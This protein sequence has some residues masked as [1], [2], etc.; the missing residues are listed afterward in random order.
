MDVAGYF[1]TIEPG[2]LISI[3]GTDSVRLSKNWLLWNEE[4]VRSFLKVYLKQLNSFKFSSSLL[5]SNT[6]NYILFFSL[7]YT[8]V[9]LCKTDFV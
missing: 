4:T 7:F 6:V 8:G 5:P 3:M 1:N 9:I 2:D